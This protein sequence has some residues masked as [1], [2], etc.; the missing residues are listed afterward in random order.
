MV[1]NLAH[2]WNATLAPDVGWK[3]AYA[4]VERVSRIMLT[5]RP[6]PGDGHTTAEMVELLYPEAQARGDGILARRRIFKA[7]DALATR[8]LADCAH[9][10]AERKVKHGT[11]MIRPWRWH[12]PRQPNEEA[13]ANV[14]SKCG[15]PL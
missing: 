4:E 6:V 2:V 1:L 11:R 9:R 10:G 8:G 15:R 12:E 3:L 7:L 13:L 5:A 14:C